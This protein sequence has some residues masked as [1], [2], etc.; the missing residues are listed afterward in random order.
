[1]LTHLLSLYQHDALGLHSNVLVT[2]APRHNHGEVVIEVRGK[3]L[4]NME[5]LSVQTLWS[6]PPGSGR[7]QLLC[8][9]V[10]LGVSDDLPAGGGVAHVGG[11]RDATRSRQEAKE[12]S[13][14]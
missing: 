10:D 7:P 6:V 8:F 3:R 9:L 14:A 1:M 2:F 11:T 12:I 13:N 4:T 5:N